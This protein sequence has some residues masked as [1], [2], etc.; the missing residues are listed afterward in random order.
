MVQ[1]LKMLYVYSK[2]LNQPKYEFLKELFSPIDEI[3]YLAFSDREQVI[4]PDNALPNSVMIFDDIAC[5]K[6][7]CL[8]AFFCTGR[9]KKEDSLYLCQS[10]A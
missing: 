1:S 3:Q 6:Q 4:S 5:E 10:C 8:K 7:D 9:H 2:S